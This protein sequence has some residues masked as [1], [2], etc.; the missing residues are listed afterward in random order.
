MEEGHRKMGEGKMGR[1]DTRR[2]A[3]GKRKKE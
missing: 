3:I 2:W 1:K